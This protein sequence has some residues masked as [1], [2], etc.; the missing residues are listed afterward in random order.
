MARSAW[1]RAAGWSTKAS[2]WTFR[3]TAPSAEPSA[4]PERQQDVDV[5]PAES[6]DD[7]PQH[8]VRRDDRAERQVD[9]RPVALTHPGRQDGVGFGER[10]RSH[11]YPRRVGEERRSL[12]DRGEDVE[13]RV[14][15]EHVERRLRPAMARPQPVEMVARSS[16]PSPRRGT[17]GTGHGRRRRS[18]PRGRP[19]QHPRR[20]ARTPR[21]P[22]GDRPAPVPGRRRCEARSRRGTAGRPSRD[23]VARRLLSASHPPTVTRAAAACASSIVSPTS[24]V[25]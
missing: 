20:T 1:R 4:E 15:G 10:D 11:R 23:L 8:L 22:V 3:G 17:A 13:V 24:W 5:E 25:G 21:C 16:P 19:R 12:Q 14:A 2:T 7:R 18:R 9:E 6:L